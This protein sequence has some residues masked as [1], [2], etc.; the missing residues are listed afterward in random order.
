VIGANEQ[1][2][3]CK[4]SDHPAIEMLKTED[5]DRE[6]E[7]RRLFYVAISRAKKILYVTYSGKKPSYYINDEM[8]ALANPGEVGGN[9]TLE[10]AIVDD[11]V[12]GELKSWRSAVSGER[13][14]PAFMILS[15]AV[16]DE[17]ARVMPKDADELAKVKGIGPAKLVEHGGKILDIVNGVWD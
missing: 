17:I 4:A 1:N 15:N 7:E 14:V 9:K 11:G 12:V 2:F 3:P 10:K 16:I 8:R 13:G 5:Y 6:E